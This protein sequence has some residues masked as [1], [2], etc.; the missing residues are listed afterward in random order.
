VYAG[1]GVDK[2]REILGAGEIVQRL[3]RRNPGA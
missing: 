1:Q 2:I 3:M